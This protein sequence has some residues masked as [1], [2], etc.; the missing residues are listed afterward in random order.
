MT[1][2]RLSIIILA[3]L[4]ADIFSIEEWIS[5]AK[6]HKNENSSSLKVK[7]YKY[8]TAYFT[9]QVD[10]FGF[11][12]T[13]T[14]QMRYLVNTDYWNKNNGPIL[15]YCGN[16]G[17]IEDFAENTGFMWDISSQMKAMV[18]FAEHRYY[19]KSMPYGNDSFKDAGHRGFLTSEQA[20]ADYAVF[21]TEFKKTTKGA[22][23]S[24]VV[25][26]GGSYGGMLAAWMRAKYPQIII[27]ALAASAPVLQFE[28]ITPCES[29]NKIV[30]DTFARYGDNCVENIRRS[31]KILTDTFNSGAAGKS[32]IK[33]TMNV[34]GVMETTDDLQALKSWITGAWGNIAMVE[35][36]Y[37][38]NFLQNLPA[39]PIKGV[40]ANLD[41]PYYN[42]SKVLIKQLALAT[43]A[44]FNYSSSYAGSCFN[45]RGEPDNL[46]ADQGWNFQACSEMIMPMCGDGVQDF[47]EPS[48]WDLNTE[49]K[50]CAMAYGISPQPSWVMTN[51]LGVNITGATNIIFSN[52]VLDP[53]H[54]GGVLRSYPDQNITA[55]IIPS[56]A[57]HLDLRATNIADPVDIIAARHTEIKIMT[58]WIK[59]YRPN[60][61]MNSND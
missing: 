48:Q 19:G 60:S 56:G 51:Y 4:V 30:T 11:T 46:G 42:D 21:L 15:F 13:D 1:L 8:T 5:S 58:Q 53:W 38:A 28:G 57:H 10:H 34:C 17:D 52:G 35:Y 9:Q 50:R 2:L 22:A 61:N 59:D 43:Q 45:T 40:C 25:A 16:E 44:F 47:F 37:P 39:W 18:V 49:V 27:G 7:K 54:G 41:Q 3:L 33:Q 20:L 31:W 29:Y 12:N 14:Y 55:L 24:P 36:P 23:Q 6:S 32:Y 26:F